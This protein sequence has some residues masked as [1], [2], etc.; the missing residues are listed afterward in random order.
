MD[1]SSPASIPRSVLWL[2]LLSFVLQVATIGI[3]RQY[4]T[5]GGEDHFAFGWEMGRIGRSIALGQGFSS[6]YGGDTGPSAWEPPLYPYLMGAVFNSLLIVGVIF[7]ICA[8]ILG[9]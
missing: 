8:G 7:L 2:I 3:A 1:R 4:R 5:R 9:A 6:P